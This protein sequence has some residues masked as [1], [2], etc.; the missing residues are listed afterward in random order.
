MI[1]SAWLGAAIVMLIGVLACG[2][3][4]WRREAFEALIALELAGIL[5]TVALVCM[6]VGFQRSSYG[7]VPILAAVLTWVGALVFVRFLGRRRA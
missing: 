3:A 2:L 7:D 4:A 1:L 5:T 6:T